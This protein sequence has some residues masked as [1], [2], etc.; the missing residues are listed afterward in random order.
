MYWP[1]K[2][3]S[4]WLFTASATSSWRLRFDLVSDA[5]SSMKEKPAVYEAHKSEQHKHRYDTTEKT[6]FNGH[7]LT[8]WTLEPQTVTQTES[9]ITSNKRLHCF[10]T[11]F[12][13]IFYDN[14]SFKIDC[15]ATDKRQRDL[16]VGWSKVNVTWS[17]NF[18]AAK[19]SQVGNG[20]LHN[21]RHVTLCKIVFLVTSKHYLTQSLGAY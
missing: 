2:S 21:L 11:R 14:C 7:W 17:H 8:V 20:W 16:K 3:T 6:S 5:F 9:S 12:L 1:K 13:T 19:V 10:M 18:L 15:K 4:V